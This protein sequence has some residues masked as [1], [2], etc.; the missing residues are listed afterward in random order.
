M[1]I[2]EYTKEY[3]KNNKY[4][5]G[6]LENLKEIYK[7]CSFL[8]DDYIFYKFKELSKDTFHTHVANY[9]VDLL[10]N[11]N[12]GEILVFDQ[13]FASTLLL[14]RLNL[15]MDDNPIK[16]ICVYRDPRDQYFARYKEVS[17]TKHLKSPEKFIEHYKNK[18][19]VKINS[20]SK[21]RLCIRFEDLVNDYDRTI[22]KIMD[23]IGIDYSCH[24]AKK[25]IFDPEISKANIGIWKHFV[26]QEAMKL[27]E[28]ELKEYCY[29]S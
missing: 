29:N 4:P 15:Y 5:F 25:T 23:F 19:L 17:S 14:D 20:K 7:N 9:I 1:F 8:N 2:D 24:V 18:V 10:N 28:D 11:V 27:I 22:K 12:S 6:T 3:M 16:E 13:M 21:N 26:D